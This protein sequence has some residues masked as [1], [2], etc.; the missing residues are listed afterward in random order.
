MLNAALSVDEWLLDRC[1]AFSHWTQRHCGLTSLTWERL[2]RSV[3]VVLMTARFSEFSRE[4]QQSLA[5]MM[6]LAVIIQT[7][8]V[9]FAGNRRQ[10]SAA[11][12][13]IRNS[14]RITA[15]FQRIFDLSL[16]AILTPLDI[17]AKSPPWY[18][19]VTA[20]VYFEAC[21]DLP[22]GDST[23]KSWLR[24]IR[25]AFRQVPVP[26]VFRPRTER[27]RAGTGLADSSTEPNNKYVTKRRRRRN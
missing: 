6:A 12:S 13:A 2:F 17:L 23:I 22:P 26:A 14:K 5:W 7:C 11:H 18:Q 24:S 20:A 1:E 4:G 21:D 25:A 8:H 10:R 3:G 27:I 19:C 15:R 9:V 16:S